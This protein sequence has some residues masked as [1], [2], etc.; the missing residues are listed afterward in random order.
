MASL[1]EILSKKR[2]TKALNRLGGCTGWSA[3]VLFATL[4]IHVLSRRGS[5]VIHGSNAQDLKSILMVRVMYLVT[6]IV[7]IHFEID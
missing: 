6:V 1:D 7:T 4:R 2:K 5:Y 3:P